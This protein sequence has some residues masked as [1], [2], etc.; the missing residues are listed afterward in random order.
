MASFVERACGYG[1]LE[2]TNTCRVLMLH[3]IVKRFCMDFK[4]KA[5]HA[6]KLNETDEASN[7][8]N[9][10]RCGPVIQQLI[11]RH[12]GVIAIQ[13]YINSYKFETFDEEMAFLLP[14]GETISFANLQLAFHVLQ[15]AIKGYS[16]IKDVVYN[17]VCFGVVIHIET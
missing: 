7:V 15:G 17:N 11:F 5:E 13:Q 2:I 12:R 14:E 9:K 4:I 3:N 10:L 16:P 8:A 1:G 6:I